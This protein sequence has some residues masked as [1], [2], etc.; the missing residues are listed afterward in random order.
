MEMEPNKSTPTR[1][2]YEAHV[3]TFGEYL[4]NPFDAKTRLK[5]VAENMAMCRKEAGMSQ[6]DVCNIIGCAPQTY[7]GYEKGK[8]EPTVETLVRLSH[9]YKVTLDFL[10]GRNEYRDLEASEDYMKSFVENRT[11]QELQ[12]KVAEMEQE[13]NRLKKQTK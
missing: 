5:I 13:L 7:S 8:H 12:W 2:E 4:M 10:I 6:R 11:F 3:G 9:L 1:L